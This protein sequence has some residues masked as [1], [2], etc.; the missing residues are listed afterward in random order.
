MNIAQRHAQIA[1]RVPVTVRIVDVAIMV[2]DDNISN[3]VF[4][5]RELRAAGFEA[6]YFGVGLP[7]TLVTRLQQFIDV[8][9]ANQF[10]LEALIQIRVN[11]QVG[12]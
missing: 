3:G 6:D 7:R 12:Q 10:L 11:K 8:L 4:T 1:L 9:Q 5:E 2:I